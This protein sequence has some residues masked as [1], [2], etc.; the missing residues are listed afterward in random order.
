VR[1]RWGIPVALVSAAS[2]GSS[3]GVAKGLIAAGW[4]PGAVVTARVVGAAV[5]LA[6]PSVLA[7]RGR[8]RDLRTQWRV[9]TAY[10]LMG[11]AGCQLAYFMAVTHVSVGVALLLEYLAPVLIV[12]WLWARH[13]RTPRSMTLI[14]VVLALGGL[15]LVLDLGGGQRVDG[16]GVVWGLV[17][18]IGLC[19][20]FLL[21]GDAEDALPPIAL[22]GGGL[23]V[24]GAGLA[25]AGL[26]GILP[27][28]GG[29]AD[30]TLMGGT[31]P[32]W[33]PVAEL[34]IVSAALAYAT[35]VLAVRSLGSTVGSF[36]G[37]TEVLFAVLFAWA[38]VG[39]L[40]RPVQLVGGVL[41]VAGV[42]A[43]RTADRAGDV[44]G[45]DTE[46]S[47]VPVAGDAEFC[48]PAEVD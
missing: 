47:P 20:Y 19:G 5:L 13:G 33:V 21:A 36:V 43:V 1:A 18:A 32:W 42:V 22:A 24:G 3:G 11:V 41:I 40:P 27:M 46:L 37:L 12:G 34:A 45:G 35:G 17:A 39:E 48:L 2:F 28:E 31:V 15:V 38:L 4:S 30:V 10:G 16:V 7:L 14:G 6:V 9:V 44:T 26:V 29:L 25:A 23:V 8:W